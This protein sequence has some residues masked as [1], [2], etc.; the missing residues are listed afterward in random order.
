MTPQR[1]R[2]V[3]S[4]FERALDQ[5][6]AARDGF[7]DAAGESPS[8]AAEVRKLLSGD[9]HA[10]SFLQ[11][12]VTEFSAALLSPGELVGGRFRIVCLLGRGG[13]GVV[14]RADDLVLSR[15]VAL[16]ASFSRNSFTG[17]RLHPGFGQTAEQ[18]RQLRVH[19]VDVLACQVQYLMARVRV[20]LRVHGDGSVKVL[21]RLRLYS[22][23]SASSPA[24]A[25]RPA[26]SDNGD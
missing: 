2:R 20:H 23:C 21:Q 12:A 22:H 4:L 14:Y 19:L 10:G 8:V 5:S 18:F 17:Q 3:K 1:W 9:A 6:A 26:S 7:I 13:T 11:D 15:Q 16:E 24:S 25:F